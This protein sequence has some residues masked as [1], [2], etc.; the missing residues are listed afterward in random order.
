[1]KTSDLTIGSYLIEVMGES[2]TTYIYKIVDVHHNRIYFDYH[3][4]RPSDPLNHTFK[5]LDDIF[6]RS[7]A[8]KYYLAKDEK[9]LLTIKLKL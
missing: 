4:T 5:E 6:E 1:M 2:R 7:S 3:E 8:I 9:E